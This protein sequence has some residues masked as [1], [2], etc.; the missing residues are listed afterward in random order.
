MRNSSL[1]SK[2]DKP[3]DNWRKLSA[4]QPND[5]HD[6]DEITCLTPKEVARL[7]VY[8]SADLMPSLALK[9]FAGLRISE[10]LQLEW[11]QIGK[12]GVIVQAMRSKTRGRRFI[13]IQPNLA[14]WLAL[15]KPGEGLVWNKGQHAFSVAIS[16]LAAAA[17]VGMECNL[18]RRTFASYHFAK[19][20]NAN[21][22]ADE[23]GSSP[24]MV[25][26]HFRAVATTEMAKQFWNIDPKTAKGIA[27][28]DLNIVT[29]S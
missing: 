14:R 17:D 20:K 18:F 5:D 2:Q 28:G 8:C 27:E 1:K 6:A 19:F 15:A 29:P 13:T 10:H 21:Y 9:I 23:M 26:Q 4:S 11:S 25:C 12:E 16:R 24:K 7:F 3:T 22:T